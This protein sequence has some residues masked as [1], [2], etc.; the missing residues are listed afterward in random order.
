MKKLLKSL[1]CLLIVASLV[2]C[3]GDKGGTDKVVDDQFD[4][5]VTTAPVGMHPIKTNDAPSTMVCAQI[6]ETLYHRSY[7]GTTYE[8]LLAAE[9]PE[10][11]EDGL[12]ATI[13]LREGVEFHDGTPFTAEAVGYLIDKTKDPAYGSMRASIVE[14]IDS[15]TIVDDHTIQLHLAY[16]DGV[17]IAKLAHSNAAIVNPVLDA[18][19]DFLVNPAGAGTGAYKFES[20]V[21]GS[22]YK[23]VANENYW[24]GAPEVKT[25][26][27]DVIA[28]ESTAVARLQTGEADG[29]FTVTAQS[30]NTVSNIPDYT[31]VNEKASSIYYMALRS[32]EESSLNPL[33][34]NVEFRTAILQSL[35][36]DTFTETM[37]NG[38]ASRSNSIVGPTL[39]GYTE[40]MEA[41]GIKYDPEA[42]KATID[43]NGWAGQKITLLTATRQWQQDLAVF[44]QAEL[45]KVG[46]ECEIIS[47][48]W[49]AFLA[50][51]KLEDK[52]DFAILTWSNVTGDGQQMLEPNFSEKNG[53]RVKYNNAEFDAAVEASAR[54]TVLEERQAHMLDAVKKIQGDAIVTP[55]YSSNQLYVYNSAKFA[56]V[57]LDKGGVFYAKDFDVV[58]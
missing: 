4:V 6:Y 39:V 9:M 20:A 29:Y 48:E 33:M 31:A 47:E 32:H 54:T 40:A 57:Q 49:S 36:F 13:K 46:I 52:M 37:M 56:D 41:A 30:Y 22:N 38:L 42:A 44:I 53:V 58:E 19:Q 21:T 55:V 3:G 16:V 10:F 27:Y 24:G 15:Y 11:S 51:A 45:A 14:S 2:A 5:V 43:K 23:L 28:D 34:A 8:P 18:T 25:V 1:A 17:L 35:D 26:N 7:D 50:N 12:T